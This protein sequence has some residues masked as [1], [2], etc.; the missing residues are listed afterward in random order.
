M[1]LMPAKLFT[2]AP[3]VSANAWLKLLRSLAAQ[4]R[5]RRLDEED[6]AA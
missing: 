6:Q 4:A 3:E 1:I 5:E 2:E